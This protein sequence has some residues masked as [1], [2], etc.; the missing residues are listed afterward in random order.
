MTQRK[1]NPSHLSVLKFDICDRV[2]PSFYWALEREESI[3]I[4]TNPAYVHCTYVIMDFRMKQ[5]I[6]PNRPLSTSNTHVSVTSKACQWSIIRIQRTIGS[7]ILVSWLTW[8]DAPYIRHQ[9]KRKPVSIRI[10]HPDSSR[11][12]SFL[13]QQTNLAPKQNTHQ[14]QK[15]S[16]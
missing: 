6:G 5:T 3:T 7:R 16:P 2:W 15:F 12:Y 9:R 14:L 1:I 13:R 8:M 10:H 11:I 4:P